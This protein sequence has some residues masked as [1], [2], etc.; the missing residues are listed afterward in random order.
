MLASNLNDSERFHNH[1]NPTRKREGLVTRSAF[2]LRLRVTNPSR[3]RVGLLCQDHAKMTDVSNT[4]A[5]KSAIQNSRS[6]YDQKS[7]P[8]SKSRQDFQNQDSW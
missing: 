3:L 7:H 2:Y 5:A 8:R 1:S 6:G 4:F